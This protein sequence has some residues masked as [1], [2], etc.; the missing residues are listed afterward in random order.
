MIN[1]GDRLVVVSVGTTPMTKKINTLLEGMECIHLAGVVNLDPKGFASRSNFEPLYEF[2]LRRPDDIHYT[3]DINDR[4]TIEWIVSK[5]PDV[6]LQSGW[7]QIW[8][9]DTLSIPLVCCIGIHAAPLPEGRGAAILNWKL[10]EGGGPWGNS[11]FIMEER[12]DMGKIIDFEPFDLEDRDDIRTAYLKADRTALKMVRRTLPKFLEGTIS[13]VP[14]SNRN[15]SR[16]YKRTP[17]DGLIQFDW[18]S[19]RISNYVRALTHPYP[20][21]FFQTRF[22]KLIVWSCKQSKVISDSLPGVILEVKKEKGVLVKAGGP[23]TLW[24]KSIEADNDVEVWADIWAN[25]MSLSRG[26]SLVV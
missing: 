24:L 4:K 3:S 9:I 22:G 2:C 18:E 7:S 11:M 5:K 14:Q 23:T 21:A 6:I 16:Y 10:I 15:S 17:E 19:G 25:E 12:T 8:G 20:G 1:N 26:C 13:A